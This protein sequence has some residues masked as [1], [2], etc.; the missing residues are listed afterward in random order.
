MFGMFG[1]KREEGKTEKK[2]DFEIEEN[3]EVEQG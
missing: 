2:S 1:R 3:D